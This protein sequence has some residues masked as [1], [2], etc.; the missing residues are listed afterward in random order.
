M[1]AMFSN[2][3]SMI[4]N[5]FIAGNVASGTMV[6]DVVL[7]SEGDNKES[8]NEYDI[9]PDRANQLLKKAGYKAYQFEIPEA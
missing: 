3:F 9:S 1:F 2:L 8:L 6:I 4:G 7:A 5:F